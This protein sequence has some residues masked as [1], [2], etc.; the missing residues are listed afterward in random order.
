ML[1]LLSLL[2]EYWFIVA[3][4]IAIV[5]AFHFGGRPLAMM[6]ATGGLV[7]VGYLLGKKTVRDSQKETARVINEKREKEYAK[8]DARRTTAVDASKRLRDRSF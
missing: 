5:V 3:W 4:L 1:D 8:I 2:F 7:A 6:V